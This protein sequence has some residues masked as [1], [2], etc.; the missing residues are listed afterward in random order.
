MALTKVT[1]QLNRA[2][3][4]DISFTVYFDCLK[5]TYS[6]LII[7]SVLLFIYIQHFKYAEKYFQ[8]LQ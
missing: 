4:G 2:D 5:I 8:F 1:L 7:R 3:T 6:N